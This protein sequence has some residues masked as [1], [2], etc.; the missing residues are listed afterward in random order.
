[1]YRCIKRQSPAKKKI[2]IGLTGSFASGKTTVAGIFKSFGAG[3]IDADK[4][5]HS[6]IKPGSIPYKK[7]IKVFG[8]DVVTGNGR[9]DRNKLGRIAFKDKV[10]LNKLNRILHPEVINIINKRI[11]GCRK[12]VVVVDAPLLIESGLSKAVDKLI[13]V[14]ITSKTQIERARAKT[15]LSAV[16]ISR[17]I[18]S[19]IS[20]NAK[21]RFANFIIDNS[22]TIKKT[23]EQAERIRRLLWRN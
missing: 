14:T 21:L 9:I 18:K 10:L 19:Q 2:I 20:Q 4:I 6:L 8:R 7:I 23:K 22:G 12:K 3:I 17:R 1:M 16:D 15:G 5:S 13:V 11:R